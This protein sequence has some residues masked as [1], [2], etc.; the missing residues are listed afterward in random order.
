MPMGDGDA[1]AA[2]AD[3]DDDVDD[4][5]DIDDD[6]DDIPFET[7]SDPGGI[8]FVYFAFTRMPG[9]SH[10]R[11]IIPVFRFVTVSLAVRH[12]TYVRP[13]HGTDS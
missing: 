8:S 11:Y 4:D 5:D 13:P 7:G 10:R 9:D 12:E 1:A 2:A 6:D 3:D